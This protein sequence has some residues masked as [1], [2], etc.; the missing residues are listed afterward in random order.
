MKPSWRKIIVQ[1][2]LKCFL[3]PA[4]KAFQFVRNA[5]F[6]HCYL[7]ETQPRNESDC[8]LNEMQYCVVSLSLCERLCGDGYDLWPAKETLSRV[9]LWVVPAIVLLAHFHFAPL[10][11]GNVCA[12]LVHLVGDPIDS[13]RS[14]L[15][16]QEVNRRLYRRAQHL[17][18][19]IRERGEAV[20][21]I[22]ATYEELGWQEASGFIGSPISLDKY[23]WYLIEQASY[24]LSCC[25][26][27]ASLGTWA[28]ILGFFAALLGAF[29]RTWIYRLNNQT[30]HTIAVVMLLSHFIPIVK[31]SGDIGAFGSSTSAMDILQKLRRDLQA[32]SRDVNDP[33]HNPLFPRLDFCKDSSWNSGADHAAEARRTDHDNIV[34]WPG[35]ASYSGMNSPWRPCK[36]VP[37]NSLSPKKDRGRRMLLLISMMFVIAGSWGPAFYLSY[38][39]GNNGFGCRCLAWTLI[40]VLWLISLGSDRLLSF[41]VH[42]LRHSNLFQYLRWSTNRALWLFTV[43]KDSFV[44]LIV[45]GIIAAVQLGLLNTCWC[46][47]GSLYL[48]RRDARVHLGPTTDAEWAQ[49]WFHWLS[50]PAVGLSIVVMLIAIVGYDGDRARKLLCKNSDELHQ[51]LLRLEDLRENLVPE[52]TM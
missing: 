48:G 26:S 28:A 2:F 10:G 35:V 36:T 50:A 17:F 21:S 14:M 52:E 24:Q 27:E 6:D 19:E 13:I 23:E 32:H 4:A 38:H 9:V 40:L 43:A 5:N 31:I 44:S 42:R 29:I 1:V 51:S 46:L 41:G 11:A 45:V 33:S 47:S 7:N 39:N 12:V 30:S 37:V 15:I 22:W 25:R 3:I 18:G 49:N 16:R 20:A 8:A 34:D